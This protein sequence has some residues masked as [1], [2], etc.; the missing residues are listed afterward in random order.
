MRAVCTTGDSKRRISSTA[1]A[2]S[3]GRS[4]SILSCAECRSKS[5]TPLPIRWSD[6]PVVTLRAG[7]GEWLAAPEALLGGLERPARAR[8]LG[9]NAV[10]CYR[11]DGVRL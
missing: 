11:L 3:D 4:R 10:A 5:Q 8:V 7:Y 9:E 2:I 1:L 6:W